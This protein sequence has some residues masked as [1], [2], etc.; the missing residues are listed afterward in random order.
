MAARILTGWGHRQSAASVI[1]GYSDKGIDA[2]AAD[3]EMKCVFLIQSKWRTTGN[4]TLDE[5]EAHK[6]I[7][8]M[9]LLLSGRFDCFNARLQELRTDIESVLRQPGARIILVA[10]ITV[11]HKLPATVSAIF[12]QEIARSNQ[13]KDFISLRHLRLDDF[14]QAVIKGLE[15]RGPTVVADLVDYG[16]LK[17]PYKALH[18]RIWATELGNWYAEHGDLLFE[19]NIRREIVDSHVNRCIVRTLIEEPDHFWYFNNGVRRC[20]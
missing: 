16:F 14:R 7:E 15:N 4:K 8:G 2:I 13:I 18:G 17:E 5:G 9:R 10:A 12:D 19:S 6:L 20:N 3:K 11:N 1:D